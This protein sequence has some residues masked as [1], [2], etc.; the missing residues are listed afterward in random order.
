MI[1]CVKY[2]L[3]SLVI[4]VFLFL[5]IPIESKAQDKPS[6]SEFVNCVSF[7]SRILRVRENNCRRWEFEV[8]IDGTGVPGPEGPQGPAGPQGPQGE[9]GEDADPA[10]V[11]AA[12]DNALNTFKDD[13]C[14]SGTAVPDTCPC[15]DKEFKSQTCLSNCVYV[16]TSQ[17]A[18][19]DPPQSGSELTATRV[20][21]IE[22]ICLISCSDSLSEQDP[23]CVTDC[24]SDGYDDDLSIYLAPAFFD[25]D[26]NGVLDEC[27][28]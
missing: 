14:S 15:A 18:P 11:Q 22:L 21:L 23:E 28:G 13:L 26:N 10:D 19:P 5:P 17:Q 20:T 3:A 12:I 27:E 9:P 24:N 2:S 6:V 16:N 25:A 8:S 1:K 4:S 7:F